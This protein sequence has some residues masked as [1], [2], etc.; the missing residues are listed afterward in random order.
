MAVLYHDKQ[1]KQIT[2]E[3]SRFFQV[4]SQKWEKI[5]AVINAL[6]IKMFVFFFVMICF[7][8]LI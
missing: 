1:E 7:V 3:S 8:L 4:L 2:T 5:L 6:N